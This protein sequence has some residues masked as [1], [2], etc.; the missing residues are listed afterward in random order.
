VE[1]VKSYQ[2]L[3]VG[4]KAYFSKTITETDII[5]YAG[6]SG[7][8]NPVHVNSEY[9]KTTRFKERIA[10]GTLTLSLI[11]PV[12]GMKL[13]GLGSV[14]LEIHARF[15]APVKIG[16]TI[17]AEVEVEEKIEKNKFIRLKIRFVNQEG[18]EVATGNALVL[19]P[20]RSS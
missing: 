17:T 12:I 3:Q 9:A 11:A 20:S 16:D 7:D 18:I 8:F 6:I 13:P 4:E 10:H 5:M 1:L 14:L 2:E 15:N 19:P